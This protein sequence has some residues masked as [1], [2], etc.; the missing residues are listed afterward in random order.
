MMKKI[1]ILLGGVIILLLGILFY[2]SYDTPS[3]DEI[4]KQEEDTDINQVDSSDDKTYRTIKLQTSSDLIIEENNELVQVYFKD[5]FEFYILNK[6]N[7]IKDME[8]SVTYEPDQGMDLSVNDNWVKVSG[9]YLNASTRWLLTLQDV[10]YGGQTYD[11]L[12]IQFIKT[13]GLTSYVYLVEDNQTVPAGQFYYLNDEP[14]DFLFKFVPESDEN[15]EI[16]FLPQIDKTS[17][18]AA[19]STELFHSQCDFLFEWQDDYILKVK[20]YDWQYSDAHNS[21]KF[22]GDMTLGKDAFGED[23]SLSYFACRIGK[24]RH[25]YA[26][27]M[28]DLGVTQL[29]INYDEDRLWDMPEMRSEQIISFDTADEA[30]GYHF[31]V[32]ELYYSL[33]KMNAM[34]VQDGSSYPNMTVEDY[35]FADLYNQEI[36]FVPET[37]GS[38]ESSYHKGGCIYNSQGRIL[39]RDSQLEGFEKLRDDNLM[40][41]YRTDTGE[42]YEKI[43]LIVYNAVTDEV[44]QHQTNFRYVPNGIGVRTPYMS[45]SD[46]SDWLYIVNTFTTS[47]NYNYAPL[48]FKFNYKTGEVVEIKGNLKGDRVLLEDGIL[49]YQESYGDEMYQVIDLKQDKDLT[50]AVNLKNSGDHII[51]SNGYISWTY[52]GKIQIYDLTSQIKREIA[53]DGYPRLLDIANGKLYFYK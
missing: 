49:I 39:V 46:Q 50:K 22:F 20:C 15:R 17:V 40:I 29:D 9:D 32:N 48:G 5:D 47:E 13:A 37:I 35:P 41:F 34:A 42:N 45:G 2:R 38:Y 1:Y 25:V 10:N 7:E 18:E 21:E 14:K 23:I 19:I 52:D 36:F 11:T 24:Q 3:K 53:V 30:Q 6:S 43:Q 33:E 26:M 28:Y 16:P 27:D 51:I 8:K 4:H 44:Y 31:K 12:E